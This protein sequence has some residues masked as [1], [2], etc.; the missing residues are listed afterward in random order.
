MTEMWYIQ[1]LLQTHRYFELLMKSLLNKMV[2]ISEL[3][4]TALLY[5][6]YMILT[7]GGACK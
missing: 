3:L 5:I 2:D 7:P 6:K 1:G 4:L